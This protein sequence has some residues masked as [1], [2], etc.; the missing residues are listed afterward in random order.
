[1]MEETCLNLPELS[2]K[3]NPFHEIELT[4]RL[5]QALK[6]KSASDRR[7][8]TVALAIQVFLTL[9][10]RLKMERIELP[11]SFTR[12][13]LNEY[14]I[15]LTHFIYYCENEWQAMSIREWIGWLAGKWGIETHLMIAL[16]K[17]QHEKLD[18]F[19]VFPSEA[20]LQVKESIGDKTID[21]ILQP[22]FTSP[23]LRTT[24]QILW[25]LGLL[26]SSNQN[27]V[28]TPT[29]KELL[30]EITNG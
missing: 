27:I 2:E 7:E 12:Q 18:T 19:K 15:N 3:E 26:T 23:R 5:E 14:P 8:K 11:V 24:F 21:E 20:G 16:R 1:M 10:A 22:G 6:D 29:G 4:R 9:A 25:D 28:L 30:E 13:Q 17:L